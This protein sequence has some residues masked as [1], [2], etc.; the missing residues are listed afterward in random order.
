MLKQRVVTAVVMLL[1]LA[2]AAALGTT[3]FLALT[4]AV[5]GVACFEWLRLAGLG[6]PWPV[7]LGTAFALL[8]F[9]GAW[10]GTLTGAAANIA[11]FLS[12]AIW[13]VIALLLFRHE[14]SGARLPRWLIVI[15]CPLLLATAWVG[16]AR[17]LGGGYV[18]LVSA[19]AL[20]WVA[21][22][23]AYFAGRAFGKR[24]LAPRI[25]PGKTWA[26]VG[27]AVI[28]VL[29]LAAVVSFS[30]PQQPIF[31]TRVAQ[32]WGI[33]AMMIALLILVALSIVGDLF[34]SLLKRQAGVKDSSGLLP[35]H[36]GVF[37]RIDALLPVLPIAA[38]ISTGFR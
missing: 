32:H 27:G 17:L 20:V 23:A 2:I 8:A 31:S 1:V 24:K 7:I 36:G 25:S 34:E 15:A 9:G 28:A 19:L 16:F 21:D 26:G 29:A 12:G 30:V 38:L 5:L 10:F 11:L 13:L 35:G 18:F 3:A 6:A 14:A 33:G 22:I 4:A 37:D